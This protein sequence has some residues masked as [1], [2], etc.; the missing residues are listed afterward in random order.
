M[1]LSDISG[2]LDTPA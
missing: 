1:A 2:R